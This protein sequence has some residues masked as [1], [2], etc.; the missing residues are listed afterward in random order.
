[1]KKTLIMMVVMTLGVLSTN[2]FAS[3]TADKDSHNAWYTS[4]NLGYAIPL[5]AYEETNYDSVEFEFENG[6]QIL[7]AF[8]YDWTKFRIETNLT[9]RKMDFD[10]R[11]THSD[12]EVVSGPGDQTQS[13]IMVDA[14]WHPKPLW[15]INPFLG[16]GIGF[17]KIEWNIK[18]I[19]GVSGF[20]DDSDTSFTYEL[21]A[22]LSYKLT[23]NLN[24]DLTYKYIRASDIKIKDSTGDTGKLNNQNLNSILIGLRYRF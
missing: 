12:G 8:G 2:C 15:L 7:I 16:A 9:Y 1:M 13:A 18:R 4:F 21:L 17:T 14:I 24:V 3:D 11:T 20:L 6:P 19:S 5:D 22:G 10:K 23:M